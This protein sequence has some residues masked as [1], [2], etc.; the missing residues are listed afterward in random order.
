MELIPIRKRGEGTFHLTGA[1]SGQT[2]AICGASL[3]DPF[4]AYQRE[5]AV[6]WQGSSPD[7]YP[8]SPCSECARLDGASAAAKRQE[9]AAESDRRRLATR[10]S[11]LDIVEA[12]MN[13]TDENQTDPDV[14]AYLDD[15]A[16]HLLT[17]VERS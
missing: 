2:T 16:R 10:Q 4:P 8:I 14:M 9:V 15:V 11:V 17:I 12:Q 3:G 13:R 7:L 5:A 1:R 6:R